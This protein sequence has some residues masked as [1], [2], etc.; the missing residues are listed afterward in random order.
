MEAIKVKGKHLT[1]K[2]MRRSKDA[3]VETPKFL[4]HG[5][6]D[7][8]TQVHTFPSVLADAD[9][10]Y[11]VAWKML[12]TM[13]IP[14]EDLRG[15][16]LQM[17][18]LEGPGT[19]VFGE[20][21]QSK[22]DFRKQEA[23]P[24]LVAA[25]STNRE[26]P[27]AST[28]KLPVPVIDLDAPVQAQPA[29]ERRTKKRSRSPMPPAAPS[30]SPGPQRAKSAAPPTLM[31]LAFQS[32][33]PSD[34]KKKKGKGVALQ[35]K[36]GKTLE[37]EYD[38]PLR[39]VL[40]RKTVTDAQLQA[41]NID[42]SYFRALDASSQMD[43][44]SNAMEMQRLADIAAAKERRANA[45][46]GIGPLEYSSSLGVDA[47]EALLNAPA[48]P[49]PKFG[50]AQTIE[51]MRKKL[52]AWVEACKDGPEKED[53][54]RVQA[55]LLACAAEDEA[56]GRGANLERISLL[57][58]WWEYL[59]DKHCQTVGK[60]RWNQ[61]VQSVHEALNSKIGSRLVW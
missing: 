54:E 53:V 56:G 38:V 45:A 60:E 23:P 28:S 31:S 8:T 4:G 9:A 13:Q 24:A 5:K 17:Q 11:Q 10:I 46:L 43:T 3:P 7:T 15:V 55:F 50:K 49:E 12:Q 6:C 36:I 34:G 32:K 57:M 2:I 30:A 16:A 51:A 39:E 14:P 37:L 44:L 40:N 41:I 25:V 52:K 20:R 29:D 27:V 47:F 1:L 48:P 18:K 26:V 21:G 19:A 58:Q 22:L 33:K 59:I 42:P 61:Q 35:T